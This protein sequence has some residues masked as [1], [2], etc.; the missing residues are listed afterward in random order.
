MFYCREKTLLEERVKTR[1]QNVDRR[2]TTVKRAEIEYEQKLNDQMSKLVS[3]LCA[4]I[5]GFN[6]CV[7]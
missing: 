3:K 2:E 7:E 6:V 5:P 4:N 1:E